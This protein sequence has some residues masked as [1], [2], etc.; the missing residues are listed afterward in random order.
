MIPFHSISLS[1]ISF[2][3]LFY[4]ILVISLSLI[5]MHVYILNIEIWFE[6]FYFQCILPFSFLSFMHSFSLNFLYLFS[7]INLSTIN[8]YIS[9]PSTSDELEMSDETH[10]K[11]V[12]NTWFTKL[13]CT[14]KVLAW[15]LISPCT[16]SRTRKEKKKNSLQTRYF[17]DGLNV[18]IQFLTLFVFQ[19]IRC[20]LGSTFFCVAD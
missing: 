18:V 5:F 2:L 20:S 1:F 12:I 19:I 17:S 13:E 7:S 11:I 16:Q 9:A 4:L 8:L 3:F 10:D 6:W 15:V 14:K